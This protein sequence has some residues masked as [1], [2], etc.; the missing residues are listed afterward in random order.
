MQSTTEPLATS[1][2]ANPAAEA[3]AELPLIDPRIMSD[4]SDDM[5]REDVLAILARVPDE[6]AR[7]LAD[8]R[9]SIAAGDLASARRT[10]HRLKGMASNLGAV[11]LARMARAIELGCHGIDDV[12][13]LLPMLEQTLGETL[14]ALH[15]QR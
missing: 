4:W 14:E 3:E 12:S 2:S 8:F 7:S 5:D 10:A 11:R 15:V 13:G 1:A 9:K 6:G